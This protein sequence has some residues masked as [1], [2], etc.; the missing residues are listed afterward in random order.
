[1]IDR[2]KAIEDKQHE[3]GVLTPDEALELVQIYRASGMQGAYQNLATRLVS[4]TSLPPPYLL[5]IAG[6]FA[7]DQRV[8]ALVFAL[9]QYTQRESGNLDVWL[10]L[11][12][13]YAFLK[14]DDQ[15][16]EAS[17][18]AIE[19]GGD[20]AREA[21][22]RDARFQSLA[23]NPAFRALF[24]R[25][26]GRPAGPQAPQWQGGLPNLPGMAR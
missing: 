12:A 19:L 18:R 4:D 6:M 3:S 8:E 11:A 15:A 1:M 20:Q 5:A 21:I 25:Q 13:A 9:E 2:R 17:R 7:Q 16:I 14:R 24:P 22:M 10:D 23:S 26:A